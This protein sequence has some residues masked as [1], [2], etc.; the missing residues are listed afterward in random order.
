MAELTAAM[1]ATPVSPEDD[2]VRVGLVFAARRTRR[3]KI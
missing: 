1:A 2:S 3:S